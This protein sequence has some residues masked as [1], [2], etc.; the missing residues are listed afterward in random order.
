[1]TREPAPIA[2]KGQRQRDHHAQFVHRHDL[3]CLADDLA[4]RVS[5]VS[6]AVKEWLFWYT[7]GAAKKIN[8]SALMADA[9]EIAE[10][11]HRTVESAFPL[12]KRRMIHV[13]PAI[14]RLPEKGP[15]PIAASLFCTHF[16]SSG[17]PGYRSCRI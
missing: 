16:P 3:G 15:Q 5:T 6:I 1:M 7:R 9:H 11:V 2:A 13:N 14:A 12:C 10:Q 8:S 17:R 4:V